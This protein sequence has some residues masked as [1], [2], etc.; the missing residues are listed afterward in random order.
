MKILLVSAWKPRKGG[1]VTHVENLI[2]RS[3]HRFLILTYRDKRLKGEKDV[4]RV[5][6]LEL[7]VLRGISFALLSF[8]RALFA[9]FDIIHA[10]YAI[11]QGFAGVLIKKAKKKP[12]IL[13]VH[14]SDLTVLGGSPLFRPILRWIFNQSDLIIAVS[15]Y[16]KG[17]VID[18]GVEE[19]RIRVIYNGVEAR[20]LVRGKGRR[21]IF[22]G[23]LVWQKGADILIKAF[24]EIKEKHP[25]VR[26]VIVG[27]GPLRA[28]FE[29][30]VAKL[31]LTDVEFKGYVENIASV[32]TAESVLVLPSR[33]EGFG[34][35][36]L[37]AMARGVPVV[38][39]KTGGLLE[40]VEDGRNGLFFTRGQ[41]GSLADAVD[42]I[43]ADTKLRRRL[44]DEGLKTALKFT[45]QEMV[46]ET[47]DV[48]K[49]FEGESLRA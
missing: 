26:L 33:E 39:S 15:Q 22:I 2:K 4:I 5:P 41:A 34:I 10:H 45:W 27:D 23:A 19:D 24:K 38:A 37:E 11:P 17:L 42:K 29:G 47:E 48:Y 36:V 16:M 6:V 3:K 46:E 18:M 40:I 8:L 49:R 12:L 44:M 7:P 1:I 32:F 9:D 25:D 35:A 31:K 21:I 13:T 43:V 20:G 14:G 30:L 28:R